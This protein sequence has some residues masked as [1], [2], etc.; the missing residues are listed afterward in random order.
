MNVDSS[1]GIN[2]IGLAQ[3]ASRSRN[4]VRLS[5]GRDCTAMPACAR[6]VA[7]DPDGQYLKPRLACLRAQ[8]RH[9]EVDALARRRGPKQ[10][11]RAVA[12]CSVMSR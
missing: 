4:A 2:P 12:Q 3:A 9:Y 11:T 6:Q 7:I 8:R 1:S 10:R 5:S